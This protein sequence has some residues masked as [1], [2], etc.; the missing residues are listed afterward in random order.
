MLMIIHRHVHTADLQNEWLYWSFCPDFKMFTYVPTPFRSCLSGE[1]SAP[2]TRRRCL[3]LSTFP[4]VHIHTKHTEVT[5]GSSK[6][7]AVLGFRLCGRLCL[8]LMYSHGGLPRSGQQ[9]S[10][11]TYMREGKRSETESECQPN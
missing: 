7:P 4:N 9:Q 3:L 5:N 11:P 2:V 10:S 1:P 8:N 6:F